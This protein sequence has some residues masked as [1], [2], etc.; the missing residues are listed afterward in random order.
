MTP[1]L[2]NHD[3]DRL[4]DALDR[5]RR[6]PDDA[7]GRFVAQIY[8]ARPASR[9]EPPGRPAGD[10]T[11][12]V[13]P[14]DGPGFAEMRTALRQNNQPHR[15]ISVLPLGDSDMFHEHGASHGVGLPSWSCRT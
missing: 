14:S 3:I 5:L 2:D 7:A 10:P 15:P 8:D 13:Q 1:D 6:D 12:R 4:R 11:L 9:Q